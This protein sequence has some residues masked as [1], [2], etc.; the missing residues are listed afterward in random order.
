[1]G[2]YTKVIMREKLRNKDKLTS[3]MGENPNASIMNTLTKTS[4]MGENPL[5]SKINNLLTL[6][7]IKM[8]NKSQ[9]NVLELSITTL[10]KL[11]ITKCALYN[12]WYKRK[13]TY[14]YDGFTRM[15]KKEATELCIELLAKLHAYNNTLDILNQYAD[16]EVEYPICTPGD[17]HKYLTYDNNTYGVNVDLLEKWDLYYLS[18]ATQFDKNKYEDVVSIVDKT[19][20]WNGNNYDIIHN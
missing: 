2:Y 5:V 16:V 18:I 19:Y 7:N 15:S 17:V 9:L 8:Q 10:K 11:S 1:M 4:E 13:K 3:E 12:G 6:T 14:S 20:V